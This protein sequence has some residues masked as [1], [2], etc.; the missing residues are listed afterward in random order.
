MN[1]AL[2]MLSEPLLVDP[3]D[4]TN[5]AACCTILPFNPDR[6]DYKSVLGGIST[7]CVTSPALPL[8]FTYFRN[9]DSSM[10]RA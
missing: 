4:L 1:K 6:P 9:H 5:S 3:S 2:F 8:W 7:P 10:N